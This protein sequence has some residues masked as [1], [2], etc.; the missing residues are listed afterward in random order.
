MKKNKEYW[1]CQI[2]PIEK[3]KVPYG[4][5][6]PLRSAVESKFIKMFGVQSQVCSSGWGLTEEMKSRLSMIDHLR[7]T[8]PTGKIMGKID[9]ILN[10]YQKK[11][12]KM[13]SKIKK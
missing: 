7:Y 4:G 13:E 11:L 1:Y 6:Y 3:N 5:D 2:G 10:D 9:K 8:D 12:I